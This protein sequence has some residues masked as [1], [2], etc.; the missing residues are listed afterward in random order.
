MQNASITIQKKGLGKELNQTSEHI[1]AVKVEQEAGFKT[2]DLNTSKVTVYTNIT[3]SS[4]S[5]SNFKFENLHMK[6]VFYM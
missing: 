3:G 6:A 4:K 1:K 5:A 2:I